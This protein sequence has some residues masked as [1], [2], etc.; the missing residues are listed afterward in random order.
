MELRCL[1]SEG[2]RRKGI[3]N[4]KFLK[5]CQEGPTQKILPGLTFKI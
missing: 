5:T 1:R 3:M 2:E 4:N